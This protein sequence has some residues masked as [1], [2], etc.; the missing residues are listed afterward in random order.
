MGRKNKSKGGTNMMVEHI[1]IEPK[2]N[3]KAEDRF[4]IKDY[5]RIKNNL[6]YL[7]EVAKTLVKPFEIEDTGKYMNSYME[8]WD[9]DKFNA[10]ENNLDAINRN[11][12]N[13][14]FGV[15]QR[16]FENGKFI[17][18]DELNRIESAILEIKE[19]LERQELGL[20]RIPFVFGRYSEVKI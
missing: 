18:W 9:V 11:T 8:Y 2:I 19:M 6:S 12:Y 13:K 7:H 16:F 15:K 3:W 10:F 1:W 17:K 5:N 20:R 4:N 14:D